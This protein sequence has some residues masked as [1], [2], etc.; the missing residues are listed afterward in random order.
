MGNQGLQGGTWAWSGGATPGEVLEGTALALE[1]G[2]VRV[3][4]EVKAART[5]GEVASMQAVIAEKA[6]L[7]ANARKELAERQ[8]EQNLLLARV[9][10]GNLQQARDATSIASDRAA[11]AEA[12]ALSAAA[13]AAESRARMR[14]EAKAASHAPWRVASYRR[15]GLSMDTPRQNAARTQRT[16]HKSMD[17]VEQLLW[18]SLLRCLIR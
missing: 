16:G 4:A 10:E 15:S 5:R 18:H 1:K 6:A 12:A 17:K 14:Q 13:E 3:Q 11:K 2:K 9:A 7:E 8:A